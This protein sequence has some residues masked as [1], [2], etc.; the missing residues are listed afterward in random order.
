MTGADGPALAATERRLRDA[1]TAAGQ[2]V[3][4]GSI[5]SL[6]RPLDRPDARDRLAGRR[7]PARPVRAP[8]LREQV[9]VPLAAATVVTLIATTMTL[10]LPRFLA[11][12]RPA[13]P[14]G[15]PGVQRYDR[16]LGGP[17]PRYFVG[18][19]Q[20]GRS[21]PAT[22]G[23]T[24]YSA[25]TGR[26]VAGLRRP[27]PGRAFQAVATL[28]SDRTFVAAA[29][30]EAGAA[31][32]S[33]W[34]YRFSLGSGGRPEN[35][36]RLSSWAVP[37]VVTDSSALAA[38]ANGQVVAYATQDC[39]T[40]V[41]AVRSIPA[42]P[43]RAAAAQAAAAQAV[44][45]AAA[46]AAAAQTVG[47]A[48]AQAVRSVPAPA[49]RLGVI[50]VATGQVT[51]WTTPSKPRNL[52]LSANGTLL[53]FV[54][55]VGT[56]QAHTPSAAWVVRTSAPPGPLARR[57]RIALRAPA[58]V[59]AAALSA[60]GSVLFAVTGPPNGLVA[61]KV[62]GYDVATGTP[63]L[64]VHALAGRTV[65][66]ASLSVAVS[67]RFALVRLPQPGG[68]QELNLVSRQLRT[69][70]VAAADGLAGAVW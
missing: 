44:R 46:Q 56:G 31:R 50:D 34:F 37:G 61:G 63:I 49:V 53:S 36:A 68:V 2:T 39:T 11:G 57:S 47:S 3:A 19:R 66:P 60:D 64:P 43:V 4:P 10:V 67:G 65:A 45:S 22:A 7:A 41:P 20:P 55:S 52:S 27:G 48:A 25:V 13:A 23:L 69:V 14:A 70:P 54:A 30:W 28:G 5:R 12:H 32:C 33:T 40:Q 16:A 6:P 15:V 38:S 35:L 1:F 26:A 59:P 17:A 8:R 51:G 9:L 18:I 29:S 24:V 42:Q 62:A 21:A 58:G